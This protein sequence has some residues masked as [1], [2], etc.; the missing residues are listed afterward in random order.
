MIRKAGFIFIYTAI[1]VSVILLIVF[2]KP[3]VEYFNS[4]IVIGHNLVAIGHYHHAI[5]DEGGYVW[6][7]GENPYGQLGNGTINDSGKKEKFRGI[8]NVVSVAAGEN[9]TVA[10]KEDGTVWGWGNNYS[11]ALGVDKSK[12]LSPLRIDGLSDICYV[13]AGDNHTVALSKDG[14]VY[15]MGS[16][17]SDRIFSRPD[18]PK[19]TVI[20]KDS[21]IKYISASRRNTFIFYED[22]KVMTYGK[23]MYELSEAPFFADVKDLPNII[24]FECGR[25]GDS[26]FALNKLGK[27]WEWSDVKGL[28]DFSVY[29]GSP[30]NRDAPRLYSH[31]IPDSD[32]PNAVKISCTSSNVFVLTKDRRVFE[33]GEWYSYMDE[34][35]GIV[36]IYASYN[37]FIAVDDEGNLR[38]GNINYRYGDSFTHPIE[39]I[40]TKSR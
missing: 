20:I 37:K 4:K 24:Q 28:R 33:M 3:K 14:T 35:E 11:G 2:E 23:E 21:D 18:M 8:D 34:L 25:F 5:I 39:G 9:Y 13:D 10:L 16:L 26:I 40:K 17:Y 6:I 38:L 27:V 32:R 36:D 1:V 19:P 22:G 15:Y 29:P 31:R 7:F 12:V 30:D